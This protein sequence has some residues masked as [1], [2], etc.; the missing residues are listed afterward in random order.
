MNITFKYF[1]KYKLNDNMPD[2]VFY[3]VFAYPTTSGTLHVG[4]LRSYILP[5]IIAK[6]HIMKGERVFFPLGFHATGGDAIKIF[7]AIKEDPNKAETYGIKKS[8]LDKINDPKDVV[9]ALTSNYIELFKKANFSLDYD[10]AMS[11]IDPAY[12]KFIEWQFRKLYD[13]GY[14]IQKDYQLPWCPRE[15]QPVHLDASEA[16]IISFKGSKVITYSLVIFDGELPLMGYIQELDG[17]SKSITLEINSEV[18]YVEALLDNKKVVISEKGMERFRDLDRKIQKLKDIPIESVL[19]ARIINPITNKQVQI[20]KVKFDASEGTDIRIKVE[21]NEE[22]KKANKPNNKEIYKE[23]ESK[24]KIDFIQDLS[25]KPIYCRCGAEVTVKNVKDQW[26]I[27][28]GDPEWKKR[29]KKLV[30]KISTFPP[31]Y[32]AELYGIIDW[33]GPRPCVRRTGLGTEFPF[34]KGWIIEALSD[35]T[36]YMAMYI[37]AKA[38]N[39][40]KIKLDSIKDE[41][42]DYVFLDIG[43]AETVSSLTG[44]DI[45][46]LKDLKKNFESI[47]PLDV[48]FGGIEHKA[49]HFP[50]FIFNHAAIFPE[51]YWPKGIFL[52]WHVTSGGEKLSKHLGNYVSWEDALEKYGVDAVRLYI[53]SGAEQW[54]YF[55]WSNKSADET[56][57]NLEKFIAKIQDLIKSYKD[58]DT[59]SNTET[60]LD[61]WFVSKLNSSIH[62]VTEHLENYEIRSA[63]IEALYGMNNYLESY[64]TYNKKINRDILLMFI[65]AQL[66]MMYP[67]TPNTSINLLEQLGVNKTEISWPQIE[68][69]KIN[70]EL[71]KIFDSIDR[72]IKDLNSVKKLK[73][74]TFND[75]AS[76]KCYLYVSTEEEKEVYIEIKEHLRAATGINEIFIYKTGEHGVYDPENRAS[77]AKPFKPA[78]FITSNTKIRIPK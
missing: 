70:K 75:N 37:I 77:R 29:A 65:K 6:Y 24:N 68:K 21:E 7:N 42:F 63:I 53:A 10:A 25:V 1:W 19:Q 72:T 15:N 14:L 31:S 61:K 2:K 66:L 23:L 69:E 36:I 9:K 12:K 67:F 39:E 30:D 43:N 11:T 58:K 27:N 62:K 41:L 4:H 44:I 57:K 51:K 35:S 8:D 32:K 56:K 18:N 5:D 28:Y 17:I 47:Y 26:F 59:T 78:I 49:V 76:I 64:L 22:S 46:I 48:N 55:D 71:E 45:A 40:G 16:D 20:K 38:L 54:S 34:D 73:S 52:N 13:L 74:K 60:L 50:F 3:L 33:L